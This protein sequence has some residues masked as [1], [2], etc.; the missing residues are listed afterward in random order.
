MAK[1]LNLVSTKKKINN[2]YKGMKGLKIVS[3]EPNL[4]LKFEENVDQISTASCCI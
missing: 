1:R 2:I 3:A 4:N